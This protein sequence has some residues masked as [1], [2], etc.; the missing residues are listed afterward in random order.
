M[1]CFG[2]ETREEGAK[3]AGEAGVPQN[4]ALYVTWR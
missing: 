3:D 4:D 1:D 2:E